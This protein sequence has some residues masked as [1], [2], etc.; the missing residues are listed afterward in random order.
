MEAKPV[1]GLPAIPEFTLIMGDDGRT[2][3]VWE[4]TP[5]EVEELVGGDGAPGTSLHLGRDVDVAARHIGRLLDRDRQ[6]KGLQRVPQ[7]PCE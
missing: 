7:G 2:F 1:I 5:E 6:P 4:L 3:R